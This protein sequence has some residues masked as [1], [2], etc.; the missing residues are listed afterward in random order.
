[1]QPGFDDGEVVVELV[2]TAE[3]ADVGEEGVHEV[4][5]ARLSVARWAMQ[6]GR[7]QMVRL[8]RRISKTPSLKMKSRAPGGIGEVVRGKLRRAQHAHDGAG[9]GKEQRW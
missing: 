2:R 4:F 9:G 6:S 3:F 1:M 5:L 8:S 7:S